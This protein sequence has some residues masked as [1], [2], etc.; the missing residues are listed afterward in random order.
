[1]HLSPHLVQLGSWGPNKWL[2]GMLESEET[3]CDGHAVWGSTDARTVL[4]C[5]RSCRE[6]GRKKSYLYVF[7]WYEEWHGTAVLK[8]LRL[9]IIEMRRVVQSFEVDKDLC[10]GLQSN[11]FGINH[12]CIYS[13]S[14]MTFS[15]GHSW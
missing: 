9:C 5:W 8:W 15:T 4:H 13:P 3:I 6:E 12:G 2:R 7:S 1:M 11:I 14:W 10:S